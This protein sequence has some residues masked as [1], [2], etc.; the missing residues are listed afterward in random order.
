MTEQASHSEPNFK[1]QPKP[2]LGYERGAMRIILDISS[3]PVIATV[4]VARSSAVNPSSVSEAKQAMYGV[5]EEPWLSPENPLYGI[6]QHGGDFYEGYFFALAAYN[7]F[8]FADVLQST[9]SKKRLPAKY[10]QAAAMFFSIGVV[11]LV[12][13]GIVDV[14]AQTADLKDIPAG[15]VGAGVYGAW[16]IFSRKIGEKMARMSKPQHQQ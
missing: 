12:E 15:I 10:K 3:A 1:S 13:S 5:P 6:L 16:N 2:D 8:G 14:A 4:E 11:A 9:I 7:A